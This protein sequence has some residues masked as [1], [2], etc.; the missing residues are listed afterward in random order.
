MID[1]GTA[2]D[3]T[4][5]AYHPASLHT[6]LAGR[7]R[8]GKSVAAYRMLSDAVQIPW[9]RLCGIDPTGVLLGPAS[10]GKD[11]DFALGTSPEKI[12][13]A[14][15]VLQSV[16]RL[17]DSRIARL[18]RL[19]IDQL[20]PHVYEDPRV[21]AVVCVLEEYAGLVTAAGKKQAD[22]IRRVVGRLLREGSK[23]AIHVM[24]ILQRPEAAVLHDRAQY[25][26]AIVMAVE[27][28]D[29]VKMLLPNATPE[30]TKQLIEAH[31]GRGFLAEAGVPLRFFRSD[32]VTY[33]QYATIVREASAR[34]HPLLWQG[35][36]APRQPDS[37]DPTS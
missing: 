31:P 33:P 36:G 16:E 13:H 30:Q 18:M 19:G 25:A 37:E 5:V 26:R 12:A 10:E 14:V 20:P 17:M 15:E 7:T 6:V 28:A 29:S 23:A 24:T 8:S 3:G 22:E 11:S 9:V 21:G 32:Y 2:E 34:K 35:A 27:N 4:R 1:F